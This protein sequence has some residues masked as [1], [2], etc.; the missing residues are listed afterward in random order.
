MECF[1]GLMILTLGRYMKQNFHKFIY[2]Y[3]K[4]SFPT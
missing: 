2:I 3:K 1:S 4:K